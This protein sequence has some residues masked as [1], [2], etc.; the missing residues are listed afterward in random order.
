MNQYEDLVRFIVDHLVED[1]DSIEIMGETKD[2]GTTLRIS[3]APDDMGKVIGKG[4][5]TID[6]LRTVVR[7]AGVRNHD[8]VYVDLNE[9]ERAWSG[10]TET[11]ESWDEDDFAEEGDH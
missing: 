9:P 3:V 10:A 5:H 7:A 11:T 8:R 4:G 1:H 2:R 6:A